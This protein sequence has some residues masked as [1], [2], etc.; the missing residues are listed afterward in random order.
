MSDEVVVLKDG[1]AIARHMAGWLLGQP[2]AKQGAFAL[3]LSGG[4]TPKRPSVDV[5]CQSQSEQLDATRRC[6]PQH[7]RREIVRT[8]VP[9]SKRESSRR[10]SPLY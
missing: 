9:Q 1:N 6:C 3:S 4:S 5:F 7:I 8:V 2:L 10:P